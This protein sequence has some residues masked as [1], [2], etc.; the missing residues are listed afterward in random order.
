VK[1][2]LRD[3]V[4]VATVRKREEELEISV[5][6]ETEQTATDKLTSSLAWMPTRVQL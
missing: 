6:G 5:D 1:P 4:L 3:E 2:K